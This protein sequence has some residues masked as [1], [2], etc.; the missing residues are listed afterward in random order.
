MNKYGPLR[1]YLSRQKDSTVTMRF[2]EMEAILGFKLPK[3][4]RIRPAWWGNENPRVTQ[5][6][7][8]R[9]WTLAGRHVTAN[10]E[11]ETATFTNHR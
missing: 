9:A 8:S 6:S 5:H 3:S 4:A 10:I 7:H 1:E 2:N 11:G